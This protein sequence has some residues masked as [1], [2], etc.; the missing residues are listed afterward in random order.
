MNDT[1]TTVRGIVMT[2][3]ERRRTANDK[4]VAK[5]LIG[6]HSRRFDKETGEWVD[7]PSFR[8]RVACW[9]RLADHVCAS[10]FTGDHVVVYGRIVTQDWVNEQGEKRMGYELEADGVGH[11]LAWGTSVFTKY[12]SEAALPVI[13]D[14][15]LDSRVDGQPT[16]LVAGFGGG[17][18]AD[19]DALSILHQVGLDPDEPDGDESDP[20]E[21][22]GASDGRGRKRGR[23][24]VPA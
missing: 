20:E 10:L 12:K 21:Q 4:V 7:G 1:Y 13:E 3:P 23:Q 8:V 14:E 16:E 18:D 22:S 2:N 15:D 19:H 5:F 24:A 6:S 9:R 17:H 11:D